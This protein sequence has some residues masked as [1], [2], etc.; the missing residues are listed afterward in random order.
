LGQ[1]APEVDKK[2]PILEGS[3]FHSIWDDERKRKTKK[4][5]DKLAQ[6]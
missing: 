4:D 3:R 6:T 2:T 1:D 5:E